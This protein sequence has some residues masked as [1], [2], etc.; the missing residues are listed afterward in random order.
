M[1]GR[2]CINWTISAMSGSMFY[3]PPCSPGA[4]AHWG[5]LLWGRWSSPSVAWRISRLMTPSNCRLWVQFRAPS[6]GCKK[7][8]LEFIIRPKI[9]KISSDYWR[10]QVTIMTYLK[11][12]GT[13]EW[14]F[15]KSF[16]IFWRN[17]SFFKLLHL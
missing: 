6:S 10:K 3:P 14:K 1:H 7:S 5:T 12:M 9:I 15:Y 4:C 2:L 16:F 17:K 8:Y 11:T 13:S